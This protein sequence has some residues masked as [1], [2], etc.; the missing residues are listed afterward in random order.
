MIVKPVV[1]DGDVLRV[2]A[3]LTMN[4][5]RAVVEAGLPL[6][7]GGEVVI[8]LS[9][10]TDADS[11]ALAVLYAWQRAQKAAAGTLR[12]ENAPAGLRSIA[13]AYGVGDTLDGLGDGL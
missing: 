13:R 6:L 11:S 5:A 10:V 8:D 9:Q 12:V 3:A 7:A 2:T 1:R 4:E